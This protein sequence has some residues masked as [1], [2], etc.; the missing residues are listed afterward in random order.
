MPSSYYSQIKGANGAKFDGPAPR[1]IDCHFKSPISANVCARDRGFQTDRFVASGGGD[2]TYEP[3]FTWNG[4]QYVY[5]RGLR[6]PP[7]I[8]D[9]AQCVISTDFPEIGGF[10]SSDQVLDRLV[11]AA[12]RTY[13]ANFTDG[14]PTDCPH[15]EKNGWTGDASV[16]SDFAQFRFENTSA[17][18]KWLRDIVDAQ[19][20]V[21]D[22]PGIVPSPGWGFEWGNG[23]AWDSALWTVSWNLYRYRDDR[24]AIETAYPALVRLIDYTGT[25]A[26]ADGLVKHGLGDWI[27]PDWKRIPSVHF[28]S[29]CFYLQ[30]NEVAS[31]MAAALGRPEESARHAARAA[32]VRAAI[33]AKF[34]KPGGVFDNGGQT[35][36]SAAF[37]FGLVE[38]GE[39]KDVGARLVEAVHARNDH[40]ET[41][42]IGCKTLFRALTR[43]GRTDLALKVVLQRDAP[44]PAAWM[45]KGGG[46]FW[47]DWGEGASRNHIMFG[48]IACWAYECVAGL[49]LEDGYRAFR[50]FVVEPAWTCGLERCAVTVDSPYGIIAVKWS[51]DGA[52]EVVVPP[53]TECTA[54][55]KDG[56]AVSLQPGL[57][58]LAR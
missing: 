43:I 34:M 50:R 32:A 49:R 56:R 37:M 52:L 4:F 2:E 17:Y 15:R 57:H 58:R 24:K 19:N 45:H 25:K 29:S 47:E 46:N 27:P 35:A 23:P 12:A 54:R 26:D 7:S 51:K 39:E 28:T 22:L 44:S 11:A 48:D 33:R 38:P 40:L 14:I 21:G 10:A 1:R 30:A 3:R 6:T 31:R 8:D 55:M 5:L 42:V 20:A 53:G 13:R 36:Q 16:A 9:I 41:G 18:E